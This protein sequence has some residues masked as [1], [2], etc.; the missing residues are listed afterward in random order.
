MSPGFYVMVFSCERSS[1]I[2]YNLALFVCLWEEKWHV[3][4]LP[5]MHSIIWTFHILSGRFYL[6]GRNQ[7]INTQMNY[8]NVRGTIYEMAHPGWLE[9]VLTFLYIWNFLS[10]WICNFLSV[11][12]EQ[13]IVHIIESCMEF[14]WYIWW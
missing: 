7:V 10:V 12:I 13:K 4:K 6:K 5:I 2:S 8:L 14:R 11:R 3:V 1:S 9:S